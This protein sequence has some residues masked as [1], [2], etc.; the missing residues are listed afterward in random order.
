MPRG[1]Q[2]EGAGRKSTWTSGCRFEDTKLIR[3]P[4]VLAD[5]LLEIAH[6]L[7]ADR[8]KTSNL[9]QNELETKSKS[10]LVEQLEIPVLSTKIILITQA[11]LIQRLVVSAQ[12][13]RK[14]KGKPGDKALQSW[15]SSYDPDGIAW[16]YDSKT[17]KY[18]PAADL[19]PG[20]FVRLSKWL[21]R[22]L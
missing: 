18:T 13:I 6:Q 12:Q 8:L 22:C 9:A 1:G 14:S 4:T 21:E 11:L 10:F 19:T 16:R 15:S 7:D 5:R 3:V 2:R 20:Q 17:K